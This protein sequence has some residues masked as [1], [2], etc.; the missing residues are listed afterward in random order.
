MVFDVSRLSEPDFVSENRLPAHSSHRYFKDWSEADIAHS[1][2]ITSLNGIWKFHYAKNFSGVVP[3]FEATDFDS[4]EWDDIPVPA[5]IQLHGY[6]RPQYANT[7]YPWDGVDEIVPGEIP[8]RF[9]PVA[10][11]ITTFAHDEPLAPGE[12][13]TITFNGAESAI[14]LWLNG[15]YIGYATDSFTASEFDLTGAV[16]PGENKLAAQVFKWTSGS[17]LED[18]DFFRFSGI[19]RDV[20]LNR[21]P[22]VHVED[23]HVTTPLSDDFSRATVKLKT[24]LTGSGRVTAVLEGVGELHDDGE[25][26]L[27]IA[28]E[29]P[30]LWSSEDPHLYDL[31][32]E[33]YDEG[34]N[35]TEVVPQNVGIR[36]FRLE[37][38]LLKINGERIVFKGVNRHDFGLQGRV[39]TREETEADIRT[40]KAL[41]L[42]AVR[43][44]HYPNN[45]YFYELCDE[46]GLYVI[47]E[48]NLETHGVWDRIHYAGGDESESVPGDKLEWLPALMDRA[49]SMVHRDKNH[50]SVV[51]WSPGNESYGGENLAQVTE[52]FHAF[53]DR[54]VQYE[55]LYWDP[56]HP[57]TSDVVSHMYTPAAEVEEFLQTHRDK[58]FI[59]CE[60]AHAMG[61]SFGAVD[62]YTELAYR[63]PLYQGGFIWDFADQAILLRDRYGNEFFGYGGDNHEAP[64]D[65]DFCGNGILFADHTPKPFTQ[66][67]KYL[68][69]GIVTKISRE[70]ITI[71]NRLLFTR[72]SAYET[73][74]TLRRAGAVL[75]E[76]T[77]ETDVA[78]GATE[79]FANPVA[80]PSIPGEYTIDV[81]YHL[82]TRERW[83]EAGYEIAGD[84]AVFTAG[85]PARPKPAPAPTLVRGWHN[86]GVHGE[87]F[88]A[89][90]SKVFGQMQS[91]RFGTTRSGGRELLRSS[92][93]PNFWHA[94]TANE[95]AWGAPATDGSWL[96][97]SRYIHWEKAFGNPTCEERERSVAVTYTYTLPTT[98]ESSCT[99]EYD[100]HGDGEIV[101]TVRVSPGEG[102]PDMPEFGMLFEADADL[103]HLRWYGEGPEE[104]YVDRRLGARLDV[105]ERKVNDLLTPYNRPQEAGSRTGVRWAEVRDE[106]GTGLRFAHEGE[107]EFSALPWT[108]F[109]IENARHHS[110]LPASHRTVLRPALM[111]RGVGGDNTW[112]AQTH[113]EY[114]LP[115]GEELE[116]RFSFRGVM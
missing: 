52:F 14:A 31:R 88:S 50:P 80:L 53:D 60:Y 99:V 54:P 71:T 65:G 45:T 16:V 57:D 114:R 87:N 9:N 43:T 106:R 30:R 4:R 58:P 100:V 36:R 78:P 85:A 27:E 92:P 95:R 15:T 72:T 44:S 107:M 112:G 51:M 79:A 10:S 59:L 73:R 38:G 104:C 23:L 13:L 32:I 77:L 17:W 3:G 105:Y 29:N 70:R 5:H 90:F 47:D 82:R 55:G 6:D 67:V 91:Y 1:S 110:E 89:S 21:M 35:L 46:Y 76:T 66:E 113:P 81:T 94:P 93:T 37:D 97:A 63:E 2:F 42:N 115:R 12:R 103:Q 62:K 24:R 101:V 61:N 40:L 7:Q 41:G 69:Q 98:P 74:V 25:G 11:Y 83:A 116:F 33:V 18:Q 75:S 56:R 68:Y 109:E 64:H 96:L 84:Q 39:I 86:I 49:A 28:I 34:E 111:R 102:L 48:M 19:F 26:G 8:Q 20:T 22:A 108:P